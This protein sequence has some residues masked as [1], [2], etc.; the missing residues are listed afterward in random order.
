VSTTFSLNN[1]FAA[2]QDGL[3]NPAFAIAHHRLT[4]AP[5]WTG[6]AAINWEHQLP[7]TEWI[8]F[9]SANTAY[10]GRR[11]TGSN[12]H[13]YKFENAK[14]YVNLT[15]GVKSP[16]GHWEASVWSS[17]LT[18]TYD[19]SIIFDTPTQAGTYHAYVNPPRMWGGT[20]KYNF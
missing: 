15:A 17:N 16:D 19:R 10:R 11:N 7:L 5:A 12:L 2:P 4:N 18:N 13:P 1:P 14:W 3:P 8:G 20:I 6:S 9:A